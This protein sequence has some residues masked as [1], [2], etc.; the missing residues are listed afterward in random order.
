MLIS[1]L[2]DL[3]DYKSE[4]EILQKFK[5]IPNF[6]KILQNMIREKILV[7]KNSTLDK[8]D[9]LL[10]SSWKWG[11]SVRYL[12]YSIQNTLF[13]DNLD[14]ER[15]KLVKLAREIPP[16]KPFKDL[17]QNKS[18]REINLSNSFKQMKGDFWKT[19]FSRRTIR[20]YQQKSISKTQLSKILLWTWG[21]T[22]YYSTTDIGPFIVK[23]SPSGGSRHPMEVY[24]IILRVN[25]IRPGIYHYSVRKNSLENIRYGNFK[26][27]VV[28]LCAGQYWVKDADVVFFM[29]SIIERSMWKY[30]QDH[31]YKVLLLD[32]GH[33]GQT[34]HLVCT[35]LGL[36]PFTHAAT[37]D[38]EIEKILGIDGVSEIPV[39]VAVVG[40]PKNTNNKIKNKK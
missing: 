15:K 4:N 25:G 24:P 22:K 12:H 30:R 39:Y 8:K 7:I 16:P 14:I 10:D 6:D 20:Q 9:K 28:R 35:K 5:H 18:V 21:Y 11:H 13:E 23:T 2:D 32:A 38:K 36:G 33:V 29:T 19:L 3:N 37:K 26:D 27:L 40:I 17:Q 34:F 31:A 1:V